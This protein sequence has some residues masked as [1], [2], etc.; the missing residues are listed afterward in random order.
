MYNKNLYEILG[1]E[2]DASLEEIKKAYRKMALKYHPDVNG[3]GKNTEEIF[4][5]INIAY[6][7]LR[8][9]DKR[10]EYDSRL[11]ESE[12]TFNSRYSDSSFSKHN[13]SSSVSHEKVRNEY[14]REKHYR[15][16]S[17]TSKAQDEKKISSN[18]SQ[19]SA[20]TTSDP[21]GAIIIGLAIIFLL[22][23]VIHILPFVLLGIGV[24]GV[25]ANIE[26]IIKKLIKLAII[27]AAIVGT[28]LLILIF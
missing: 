18:S 3:N 19:G 13:A 24:I 2:R 21:I 28:I 12:R 14:N 8:D 10:R 26:E 23:I 20:S 16:S 5:Q 22:P 6:E 27:I 17:N 15:T 4:K 25:I 11:A 1:V 7:V 9:P